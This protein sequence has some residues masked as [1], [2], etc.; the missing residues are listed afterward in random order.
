MPALTQEQTATLKQVL[1]ERARL[2]L[3]EV[4]DELSHSGEQHYAELSGKVTDLGDESVADLLADLNAASIDRHVHEMREIEAAQAR[5]AD[6]RYGACA[7][8]GEDITYAR[9]CAAP[10]ATRCIVCQSR[11]E[12]THAHDGG[13]N[14]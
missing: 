2:L 5:I 13:A 12:K 8:C 11:H 14:L 10:T 4:R 9:L 3:E 1:V 7:D 6:G